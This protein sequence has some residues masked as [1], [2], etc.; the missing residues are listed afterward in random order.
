[1]E[2]KVIP[3]GAGVIPAGGA[4]ALGTVAVAY[5]FVYIRVHQIVKFLVNLT[6]A[7]QLRYFRPYPQPL[8]TDLSTDGV[9]KRF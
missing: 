1:M 9:D 8:P 2:G 7:Q 3:A 5:P 6:R 4:G